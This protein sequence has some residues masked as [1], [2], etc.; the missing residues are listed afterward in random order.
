MKGR[1]VAK[2]GRFK[3][4]K[5]RA[6]YMSAYDDMAALSP[7]PYTGR[8]AETC[9]GTTHVHTFGSGSGT[10]LVLLHPLGGNGLCWYP[11]IEELCRDR[12]VYAPDTIGTA[13]R[14]VQTA[15]ITEQ[16]QFGVW[17]DEVLAGLGADRA[18][19]LGFSDGG[20]HA[21][22]AGFH[23][24][25]RLASLTVIEPGGVIV[26]LRWSALFQI[27]RFA[28]MPSKKNMTRMNE[29]VMPGVPISEVEMRAAKASLGY[30]RHL[31]WGTVFEDTDLQSITIPSLWIFGGESEIVYP[32]EAAGQRVRAHVP[33]AEVE[34]YPGL[35][36]GLFFANADRV[37]PR[38]QD[39][40]RR[41]DR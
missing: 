34:V 35:G 21:A 41:H 23:Q 32:A 39:F 15:P 29:W 2:I 16:A 25:K 24:P 20:W 18:H 26:K 27:M 13:G 40:L 38:V 6:A 36:H 10:P 12:V 22:M 28:I 19:V 8:D 37:V 3:S 33:Q 5:A 1:P 11:V 17:L 9:F 31:P 14:S 4:D 7:I 30:Q